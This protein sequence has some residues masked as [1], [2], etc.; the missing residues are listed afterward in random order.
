VTDYPYPNREHRAADKAARDQALSIL[1]GI[2]GNVDIIRR[3]LTQAGSAVR[4]EGADAAILA[5]EVQALSVQLAVIEV[6]RSAREWHAA[7]MADADRRLAAA[8]SLLSA[9]ADELRMSRDRDLLPDEQDE[10]LARRAL[11]AL[12]NSP[13]QQAAEGGAR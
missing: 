5:G 6:L 13:R 9:L 1:D 3:R 4:P 12:W 10:D 2:A 11:D 7:D 8:P